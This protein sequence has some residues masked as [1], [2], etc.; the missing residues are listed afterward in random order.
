[1]VRRQQIRDVLAHRDPQDEVIVFRLRRRDGV[2][3]APAG[4]ARCEMAAETE[5]HALDL[6][7]L[8]TALAL[9]VLRE[10]LAE[11]EPVGFPGSCQCPDV[12]V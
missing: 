6:Q 8:G 11:G 10:R 12:S 7:V 4:L 1:M 9:Q 5:S 2:E 3:A